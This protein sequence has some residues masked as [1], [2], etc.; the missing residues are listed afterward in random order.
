MIESILQALLIFG[1]PVAM[2]AAISGAL[3][4][5]SIAVV[6]SILVAAITPPVASFLSWPPD[7]RNRLFTMAWFSGEAAGFLAIPWFV[8]L[9]SAAIGFAVGRRFYRSKASNQP[10]Q[11]TAGRPDEPL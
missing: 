2:I 8:C 6:L 9:I 11:P 1:L 7:P 10:L 4:P 3:L 5:R